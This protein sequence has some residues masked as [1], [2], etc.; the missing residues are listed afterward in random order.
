MQKI[1]HIKY[2]FLPRSETFIYAL[3]SHI[4]S[5]RQIII[6]YSKENVASFPADNL[7]SLSDRS[8]P[9]RMYACGV[10]KLS[11]LL[12]SRYRYTPF[13]DAVVRAEKP[14]LI[15]AHFG[16]EGVQSLFIKKR[17]SIPLLTTFYGH[18]LA[19]GKKKYWRKAYAR[20]FNEGDLFVVEG[21]AMART[22]GDLGCKPEKIRVQHIG[23][24]VS[25]ITFRERKV[26]GDTV[27]LIFCG[28]LV[29]KKGL[30]YLIKA[31]PIVLKR[32]P[33]SILSVIGSGPMAHA[34]RAAAMEYNVS[35][36]VAFKGAMDYREYLKEL[37]SAH[38]FVA[39]SV[40]A[41]NGD[42]EGGAPTTLI[43]ALAAGMP[44]VATRHADIPEVVIEGKSGYLVEERNHEMLAEKLIFVIEN[45]GRWGEMARSGRAHIEANY[46]IDIQAMKMEA[47]YREL[48][49]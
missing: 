49:K 4:A 29:E 32:F 44:V 46:N 12:G 48:M 45:A 39:P 23:V 38:V 15:H 34:L 11:R 22:L 41:K 24:D 31:M 7:Y 40:T 21:N 17:Y 9:Y 30:Q 26:E 28:R 14:D 6:S 13:Y 3:L 5:F 10:Q 20:L 19:Y 25:K 47:T 37:D 8:L 43:E 16:M 35:H 33:R 27:R 36:A 2:C 18:D 42:T 1:A